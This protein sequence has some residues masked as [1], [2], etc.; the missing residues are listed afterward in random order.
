MTINTLSAID[1]LI[2]DHGWESVM[3]GLME[4]AASA[5]GERLDELEDLPDAAIAVNEGKEPFS[6]EC[7]AAISVSAILARR[8]RPRTIG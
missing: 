7:A 6:S 4:M 5:P 3:D 8:R 1:C 2:K